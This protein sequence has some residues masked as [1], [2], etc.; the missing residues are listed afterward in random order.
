MSVG[1]THKITQSWGAGGELIGGS[2]TITGDT[3]QNVSI[4]IP[5]NTADEALNVDWAAGKLR[6]FFLLAD[7]DCT[8]EINSPS[9]PTD[10]IQLTGGVPVMWDAENGLP[11][12]W[13]GTAGAITNMYITTP[14]AT[15]DVAVQVELRALVDL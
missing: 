3:E 15:P 12:P 14:N 6:S 1:F 5:D 7:N 8:L 2:R 4:S 10:T 11:E 9:A 13:D